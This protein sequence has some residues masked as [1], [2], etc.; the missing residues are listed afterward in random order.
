M[1]T[2]NQPRFLITNDDGLTAPGLSALGEVLQTIGHV[3]VVAPDRNWSASGHA[4]TLH[5]PLRADPGALPNGIPAIVTNGCPSDA[6]ALGLLGLVDKPVDMVIAGINKGPN[7]GHDVT[8][9]GTV[10][11]AMEGVIG[12]IPSLAIS[13]NTW[14]PVADYQAAA[15]YVLAIV[16]MVLKHGLPPNTL[17]NVN[18]PDLPEEQIK[19]IQITRMGLRIYRDKLVQRM[20][21]FGR[22]YYWIG[23]DPPTG[24][25]E[26]GTDIG[27]LAQGYVSV[28]PIQLD[29]TAYTLMEEMQS[30]ELVCDQTPEVL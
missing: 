7:V 11:A 23:G 28:T 9:S 8:Y 19:G 18:V 2:D 4:K 27:A 15:K 5:K 22:P 12:G 26:G 6:V 30:W 20:D 3:T 13:L 14:E 25:E 10:T 16:R 24:V 17:L 29:F 1:T 21:P